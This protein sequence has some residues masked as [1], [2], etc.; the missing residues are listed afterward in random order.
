MSKNII[1]EITYKTALLAY[2]I[3]F[4]D[5]I[6]SGYKPLGNYYNSE[7]EFNGD[8]LKVLDS[9]LKKDGKHF[10][11][12]A[13][14]Q[15]KL[16][17]WLRDNNIYIDIITDCTTFPKY[18]YEI[19]EFVGDINDLSKDWYWKDKIVSII[20][21]RKHEEALEEALYIG[22]QKLQNNL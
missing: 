22:L 18:I 5:N 2:E 14:E 16:Q 3:G 15:S 19:K 17:D 11:I 10:H 13:P 1:M 21:R 6:G 8:T 12:S 20:S 4:R 7:G 9:I